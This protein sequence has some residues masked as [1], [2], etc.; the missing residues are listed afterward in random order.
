MRAKLLTL[1]FASV[2]SGRMAA[3]DWPQFH[4]PGG[5]GTSDAK[6][7]ETWSDTDNI[8]WKTPLPGMGASSPVVIGRRIFL[9]CSQGGADDVERHVLCLDAEKGDI[10]WDKTVV[11]ELPEQG[12]VR[13]DHGYA[14]STPVANATHLFVFFGKSGVFCFD[15]AG[16]QIWNTKVG[17]QLNGWGSAASPVLYKNM[18]LVNASIESQSLVA[19][20]QKTGD[21][22]WKAG[23]VNESWHAPVLAPRADGVTEVITAMIQ[24]VKSFDA[25]SGKLL[26]K[27]KSGIGWYM[28][29][30]PVFKDGI[31]YCI[32][33]RSGTGGLAIRTG[34]SGDVTATHV[35]WSLP[36]GTNVPS[37]ILHDGHVYYAHENLGV[38]NCINAKSGEVVYSE[39]LDPN[40]GQIYASPV[41]AGG[42]LYYLGRGGQ[43]VIVSAEPQFKVLSKA[44]L[45]NGRGVF[46]ASPAITGNRMLIRSNKFL[47]CIGSK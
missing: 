45:E 18:V 29:P 20:D 7:P 21:E 17:S 22:V 13:E 39:R 25:D 36:K 37:P 30:E 6:L 2:L 12:K 40:P 27:C 24:E 1:V 16:K 5:T 43:A 42:K 41:L 14:S 10:V 34:G 9:T 19:L 44:K 11:S 23:G 4:G 15:H 32:G 28:C 35:L 26:W 33:G 38:V 46:N 47:Y 31:L 3:A 8:V